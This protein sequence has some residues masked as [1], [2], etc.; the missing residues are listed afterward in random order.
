MQ[1]RLIVVVNNVSKISNPHAIAVSTEVGVHRAHLVDIIVGANLLHATN[2]PVIL[3]PSPSPPTQ[4]HPLSSLF[5]H[6]QPPPLPPP[7][8]ALALK[9]QAP[10]AHLIALALAHFKQIII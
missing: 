2:Q 1:G 10:Q 5:P 3:P 4:P 7:I 9:R 6:H 8:I